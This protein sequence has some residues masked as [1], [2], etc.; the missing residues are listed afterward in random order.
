MY[1]MAYFRTKHEGDPS[2]VTAVLHQETAYTHYI[3]G[4]ES[5]VLAALLKELI[6][7]WVT[8]TQ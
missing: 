8:A 4:F 7:A 2:I 5:T 3:A 6:H 1:S